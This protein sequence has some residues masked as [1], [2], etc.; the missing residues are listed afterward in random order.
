MVRENHDCAVIAP[1][2][3]LYDVMQPK[4]RCKRDATAAGK[5]PPPPPQPLTSSQ[6]TSN[7]MCAWMSLWGAED[8]SGAFRLERMLQRSWLF[9]ITAAR[10]W[11]VSGTLDGKVAVIDAQTWGNQRELQL[12]AEAG[13]VYALHVLQSTSD[14]PASLIA[15]TQDG[16]LS[17]WNTLTW[18]CEQ[19]L[20]AHEQSILA[21]A[22]VGSEQLITGS[23]DGTI[24]VWSTSNWEEESRLHDHEEDIAVGTDA[25]SAPGGKAG[26]QKRSRK[27]L[28]VTMEADVPTEVV[29][30][31]AAGT[32]ERGSE[33][34]EGE[35]IYEDEDEGEDED[36][37]EGDT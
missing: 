21:L 5:P 3:C 35:A 25:G 32:G 26:R 16:N 15:G 8:Q 13:I 29:A 11:I 18:Q 4:K 27:R 19:R 37:D 7:D 14:A 17:V 9:S 34:E 12:G 2:N 22:S 30:D 20:H 6:T 36:E 33:C 10:E 24:A 1:F 23:A 31:A 28:V